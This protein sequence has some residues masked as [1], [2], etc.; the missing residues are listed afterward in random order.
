M[1][2][3]LLRPSQSLTVRVIPDHL[4]TLSTAIE[5]R[6][7]VAQLTDRRSVVRES[8]VVFKWCPATLAF[9]NNPIGRTSSAAR[10][11]RR[12]EACL[13]CGDEFVLS[14]VVLV[15]SILK[16]WGCLVSSAAGLIK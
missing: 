5:F 15:E 3:T 4:C 10:L 14:D 12:L 6:A 9:S 7:P 13:P 1:A 16:I 8:R 11:G 2:R